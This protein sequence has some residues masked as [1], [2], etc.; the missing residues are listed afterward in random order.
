MKILRTYVLCEHLNPFFVTLG[1]LTGVLLLGNTVK[2]ADLVI[3]K[4]VSFFD[5]LRLLIYLIPYM[6]SFTVPMACLVAMILAFGRLNMDYELIAMRASGIAPIRLVFPFLTLGLLISVFMVA[7]NDR[8]VPSAHLAFRQQ[9]KALG[10]KQPTAY[11]EAGT[12]IK[13]F[14]PYV[15]FVYRVDGQML[16]NVRIYEPQPNGPTRTVIADRGEFNPLS[17]KKQGVRL[18]LFNG[19]VDEWDPIHPGSLQKVSFATYTMNLQSDQQDAE[20]IGKKIKE[21]TFQELLEERRRLAAQ[22]IETLPVSLELHRKIASSFAPLTFILFGLGFGLRLNHQ[23][24]LT[25]YLWALGVFLCY[26]LGS[27]GM[28]VL[29]L[30]GW[31]SPWSAMWIPNFAGILISGVLLFRTLNR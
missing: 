6:L 22:D 17:N 21:L 3:A 25:P 8:V 7:L 29:A 5:L 24:R 19:V 28:D 14:S 27:V 16:H 2:F 15:M 11:L 18:T 4:G 26:Y 9:L 13:D 1:G 12:F 23:E 20:R 10:I 30:K 31:L